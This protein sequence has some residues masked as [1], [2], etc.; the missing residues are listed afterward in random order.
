MSEPSVERLSPEG[1]NSF[2]PLLQDDALTPTSAT[3]I[4]VLV[5]DDDPV[6]TESLKGLLSEWGYDPITTSNGKDALRLLSARDGPRLAVVDWMLPDLDGPEICRCLRRSQSLH[7]TYVILLTGR[8]ES[9]DVVEALGAGADDYLRKPYNLLELHAR[10]D[11]GSRIVVQKALRESELR[12]Q[13]AFE[14]AGVGMAMVEVNGKWLQVNRALCNLLGY[15]NSELLAT[16]GFQFVTHPDD[17]GRSLQWLQ[18][19]LDGSV[20]CSQIEKRYLHKDGH[21]VWGLLT[22]SPVHSEGKTAYF[23]AQIQDISQRKKAEEA[24]RERET[25]LQLLLDSTAE[26]IYGLDL[27]GRCTFSNRACVNMLGYKQPSQLL[28]R[29][30]HDLIHHSKADG[31]PIP[32]E[33]CAVHQSFR[34]AG[35]IRVDSEVLWRADG[36]SFPA[37]YWSYPVIKDGKVTG[38][39]VTFVDITSR[40]IAEAELR[41]EHAQSELFINSVPSVLIGTDAGA[42]ITR[43]NQAA[44]KAFGLSTEE[45]FGK[46]LKDC[47]IQWINAGTA[48]EIES[49]SKLGLDSRSLELPFRKNNEQHFLGL[50]VK[51]VMFPNER[52]F[53]MLI[54]G[55]DITERL[56]LEQQLRQAQKLEAIGQLAAGIAHEINTPTQYVGDNV[57]FIKQ[58]WSSIASLAQVAQQVDQQLQ[59]GAVSPETASRL[60]SSIQESDLAYLLEEIPKAVEQSLEGVQRVAKIVHAMKEFSHPES[61]GKSSLDINRAI[62]TT[63]TVARNEWKYVCDVSTSLDQTLPLVPCHGGEFNQ[64]ILNLLVNAAHAIRHVVGDGRQGKGKILVS[65]RQCGDEVEISI[66]D[67]GCGIPLEIRSRVFEPF[68]TTKPVGQ[69]TGQG[70]ALAHNT[71]VRRHE[72][73]L[74]FESAEGEGTT[75]FIRLPIFPSE[76][77]A[78]L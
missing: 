44:T 74:W 7:Y 60:R 1:P 12:F 36:C 69:G 61:E 58:S 29:R 73:K 34:S 25:Q 10:L 5:A 35:T 63:I 42:N 18:S 76:K 39:V 11:A 15:T 62:E 45:V 40:Q 51:R 75:F 53:G 46:P 3:R 52:S 71:I 19:F 55:A 54:T 23:V 14:Y 28:G 30:M 9:N 48:A 17:L 67:S 49:W 24:L 70:L 32:I 37:E 2:R 50:N 31:S 72:G 64:V 6:I 43:W 59:A 47:G 20:S 77:E 41:N 13:S 66:Q 4:T 78:A 16:T 68:F 65:T 21:T 8:D 38:C 27:E 33:Q 57:T 22:V 26:A 56:N